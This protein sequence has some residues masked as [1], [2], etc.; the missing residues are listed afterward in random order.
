[1]AHICRHHNL[2]WITFAQSKDPY[3]PD[4]PPPLV[5]RVD[6]AKQKQVDSKDRSAA[7]AEL[8]E[9]LKERPDYYRALFNLGL[10]YQTEGKTDQALETLQKAKSLRDTLHI[11]DSSILNS[12]GWAY[13]NSGKLNEAESSFREALREDG[14]ETITL[15]NLGYLYLQKGDTAKA[16]TYLDKAK[17]VSGSSGTDVVFKL[18]DDYDQ[19]QKGLKQKIPQGKP[20]NKNP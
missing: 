16:R 2:L 7:E 12:I 6:D 1:M 8:Q 10:L 20:E 5:A 9:V 14:D 11:S 4:M 18:L 3:Q 17:Q 13:M 19:R 15:N